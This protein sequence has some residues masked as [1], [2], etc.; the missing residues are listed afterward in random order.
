MKDLKINPRTKT[1]QFSNNDID[2][3]REDEELAQTIWSLLNTNLGSV[4]SN[5]DN[6][7]LGKRFNEEYVSNVISRLLIDFDK[8]IVTTKIQSVSFSSKERTLSIDMKIITK[9]GA[10]LKIG[11]DLIVG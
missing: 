2:Y 8:R 10:K 9:E 6:I 3:V 7:M 1:F 4:M 5:N 11:G